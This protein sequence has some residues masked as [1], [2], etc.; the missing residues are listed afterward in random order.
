MSKSLPEP[1]AVLKLA[2]RSLGGRIA[3]SRLFGVAAWAAP[4]YDI[5]P[6]R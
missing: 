3:S 1:E 2:R 6:G 5:R 4:D